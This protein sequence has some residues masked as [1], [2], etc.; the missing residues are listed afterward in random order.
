[1]MSHAA[2]D[3]RLWEAIVRYQTPMGTESTVPEDAGDNAQPMWLMRPTRCFVGP[4][5]DFSLT[6]QL[7]DTMQTMDEWK[8]PCLTEYLLICLYT[9]SNGCGLYRLLC[10]GYYWL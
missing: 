8:P 7:A 2:L 9:L 10:S 3:K 5:L 1:M 6:N 4:L